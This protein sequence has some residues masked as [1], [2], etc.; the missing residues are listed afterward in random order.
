MLSFQLTM[1]VGPTPGLSITLLKAEMFIGRDLANEIVISDA[2]VSRRHARL[3]RQGDTY[4]LEDLAST[5]GT[6]VNDQRLSAAQILQPGDQIRFGETIL[7]IF[8]AVIV[9]DQPEPAQ[10]APEPA[11]IPAPAESASPLPMP[12]FAAQPAPNLASNLIG[13]LSRSRPAAAPTP[14]APLEAA[15]AVAPVPEPAPAVTPVEFPP[16]P[17]LSEEEIVAAQASDQ[18]AG[19]HFTPDEKKRFLT[20]GLILGGAVLLLTCLC[21]AVGLLAYLIFLD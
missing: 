4:L 13:A 20:A 1:K 21:S 12:G 19:I 10:A 5:N 18:P 16:L 17:V 11:R 8:E 2:D 6:Y 15:P 9:A 3:A 14:I 7:L